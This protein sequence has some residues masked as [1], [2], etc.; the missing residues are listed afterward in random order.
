MSVVGV[1]LVRIFPS[2][3]RIRN[4]NGK[5]LRISP[6]SVQIRENAGKMR[7]RITSSTYTF[8]AVIFG[9]ILIIWLLKS[10]ID[11]L[12]LF[13]LCYLLVTSTYLIITS[14]YLIVTSCCLIAIPGYF[15]LLLV[16]SGYFWFLVLVTT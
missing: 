5:I 9:K 14:G 15:W 13:F 8:Y 3:S 12:N 11:C 2:F 1:I 7:T 16:A 6:Y 10:L 4:E